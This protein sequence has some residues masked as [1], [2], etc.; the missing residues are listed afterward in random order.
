MEKFLRKAD[1]I[2]LG[3]LEKAREKDPRKITAGDLEVRHM[4][5]SLAAN[6]ETVVIPKDKMN[7]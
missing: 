1:W 3:I 5:K 2:L 7:G 6:P 4:L